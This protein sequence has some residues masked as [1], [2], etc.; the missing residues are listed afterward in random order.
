M[1]ESWSVHTFVLIQQAI[2]TD[3]KV[4]II[5]HENI[6]SFGRVTADNA[7]RITKIKTGRN[8]QELEAELDN[9]GTY[10]PISELDVIMIKD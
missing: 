9:R 10:I 2:S 4:T 8:P 5:L 7:H 6:A 3:R 1:E